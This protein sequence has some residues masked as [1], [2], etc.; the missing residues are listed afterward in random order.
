M[1][2]ESIYG[3]TSFKYFAFESSCWVGLYINFLSI[4]WGCIKLKNWFQSVEFLKA[5]NNKKKIREK[6][7]RKFESWNHKCFLSI[8]R[9]QSCYTSLFMINKLEDCVRLIYYISHETLY[10]DWNRSLSILCYFFFHFSCH[11]N[12]CMYI[13]LRILREKF[14]LFYVVHSQSLMPF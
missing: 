14:I 10:R 2:N 7:D 6:H 9:E 3:L 1:E 4:N 12:L 13:R 11:A 5:Q 8:Y